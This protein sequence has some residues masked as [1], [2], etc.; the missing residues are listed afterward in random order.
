MP[1]HPYLYLL[2]SLKALYNWN[3]LYIPLII[4]TKSAPL[5]LL[6]SFILLVY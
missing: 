1:L 6:Y 5:L 3:L 2:S 4:S